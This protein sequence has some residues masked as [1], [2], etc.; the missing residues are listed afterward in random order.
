MKELAL[1]ILDILENSYRAKAQS[2]ELYIQEDT[3]K[4]LFAIHITDD[5]IGM[6]PEQLAKVTDPFFTSRRSRKVGL[7][8]SL[9]K[10]NAERSGGSLQLE[11][12]Q[13]HGTQLVVSFEHNHLDRPILG[14]IAGVVC[15]CLAGHPETELVYRHQMNEKEYLFDSTEIK[16]A[17]EGMSVQNP[18]I[19][20]F[21]EEMIKENLNEIGVNS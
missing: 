6:S 17:L 11:S 15:M 13:D 4:N 2:I 14:D 7:G 18:D 8:L 19:R 3:R 16:A 21:I 5:G 1:H 9:L 20:K 10:Q 12:K